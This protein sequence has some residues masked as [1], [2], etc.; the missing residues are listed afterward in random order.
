MRRI[1]LLLLTV[2]PVFIFSCQNSEKQ[3]QPLKPLAEHIVMIGFDAMGSYA[4]EKSEMPVLK[5]LASEGAWTLD[6]RSVLPSSSAV[7]WA[8]MLM[9]AS[10]S[11]HGY[12][13]WGSR[14]PEIPSIAISQYGK[15]PSVY[16]Q[17]R[18]QMPE[19]K[20]AVV[21]S[22]DGII[23]FLEDQIIDINIC[24]D[25]NEEETATKAAE[26]IL[27][28][29]P[30]FTFVHFDEP[31]GVGHRDGHDSP[32]YYEELKKVDQRLDKILQAIKE[33]GIEERTIIMVVSDHGGI[34]K[35]HGGKTMEEVRVPIFIK[36]PGIKKGHIINDPIID[37]DYGATIVRMLGLKPHAAWRGKVIE[38]AFQ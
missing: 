4:Y 27:K 24:T 26:T 11:L 17:I 23:Y 19:A 18:E 12:T 9:S 15:F 7:N 6:S 38:D 29:K 25:G 22:W 37:Y 35:G 32:A 14:I 28:E 5:K 30:T 20:T 13:E 3:V 8:S 33:A 34:D 16:T 2:I 31:D 10:P 36:G 1:T 21:Y